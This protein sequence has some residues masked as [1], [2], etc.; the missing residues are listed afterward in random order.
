MQNYKRSDTNELINTEREA[1]EIA[2]NLINVFRYAVLVESE[3]DVGAWQKF[4]G[5][6]HKRGF[7]VDFGHSHV[8]VEYARDIE[9]YQM[10]ILTNLGYRIWWSLERVCT[11]CI[12]HQIIIWALHYMGHVADQIS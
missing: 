6:S 8:Y 1:K 7:A 4:V 5:L 11:R 3:D 9:F 12:D 2:I 10:K